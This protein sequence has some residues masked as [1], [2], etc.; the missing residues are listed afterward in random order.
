VSVRP[1]PEPSVSLSGASTKI[2]KGE[3]R[4]DFREIRIGG[5]IVTFAL[6]ADGHGGR[7]AAAYAAEH[8][9]DRIVRGAADGS[10]ATLHRSV[11][12]TFAALHTEVRG[13]PK[14]TAGATL[15]V[16]AMNM[17]RRELSLWNV[18]DSLGLLVHSGGF[19]EL[20]VSHRLDASEAEQRRCLSL[21]AKLGRAVND[22]GMPEGGLRAY[23]GGLA[24]TRGIGDSDCGD[25]VSPEPAH[26]TH[27]LPADGGAVVLCSDGVWDNASY[28]DVSRVL[29]DGKYDSAASAAL[30]VVKGVL[31]TKG[32]TDDTTAV[33]VLFGAG[34]KPRPNSPRLAGALPGAIRRRLS[35]ERID[36]DVNFLN[37]MDKSG[38][39][40][41]MDVSKDGCVTDHDTPRQTTRTLIATSDPRALPTTGA[42]SVHESP[43]SGKR[44]GSYSADEKAEK[45]ALAPADGP[46]DGAWSTSSTPAS[47]KKE[48]SVRAGMAFVEE[49]IGDE[50][51]E[52]PMGMRR[53]SSRHSNA[54]DEPFGLPTIPSRPTTAD[55]PTCT[56]AAAPAAAAPAAEAS[57]A[58]SRE[59]SSSSKLSRP[60]TLEV[61]TVAVD[62]AHGGS[63]GAQASSSS[64]NSNLLSPSA[65]RWSSQPTR[66]TS[67][68]G[69]FDSAV[70]A[71]VY[72]VGTPS[73]RRLLLPNRKRVERPSLP[74]HG[75]PMTAAMP[76]GSLRES[77]AA[78]TGERS[79]LTG[80]SSRCLG[81]DA[82]PSSSLDGRNTS[83]ALMR[84]EE[85]DEQLAEASEHA[86]RVVRYAQFTNL[87]YLGEGEFATVHAEV[88]DGVP[89]ALKMLKQNKRD[90]VLAV[91]GLKREIMLLSLMHHPN[92]MRA[93]ALGEEKCAPRQRPVHVRVPPCACRRACAAVHVCR[94]ARVPPCG[95][96]CVS[97]RRGRACAGYGRGQRAMTCAR[98]PSH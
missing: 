20:G 95:R 52:A 81:V 56:A 24:V 43:F 92:V 38:G 58:L 19:L 41:S 29:L 4:F 89:V 69:M 68:A 97:H 14:C 23:P 93:L 36:A 30:S 63:T 11:M 79:S 42:D 13:V 7:D 28:E 72:G 17:T 33:V 6:V 46:T 70:D 22:K 48:N 80:S 39:R 18:G 84:R 67:L 5:D 26:T 88:L 44:P 98:V 1:P 53:N 64:L 31:R 73:R 49:K 2:L 45:N 87:Q 76:D 8:A 32:L 90:E 86:L 50:R 57:T 71:D 35:K 83:P 27:A 59:L 75:S 51:G 15:T 3:D 16:C 85:S 9:L 82:T 12:A 10:T 55:V 21:G 25:I 66:R 77:S 34:Q 37:R 91:K 40:P 94:R 60:G 78:S 54:A 61:V 47:M 96:A 65:P 62:G 74:W